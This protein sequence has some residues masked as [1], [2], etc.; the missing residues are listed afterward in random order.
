MNLPCNF[1]TISAD[2]QKCTTC[3]ALFHT[4]DPSRSCQN[5]P[6][7]SA[8]APSNYPLRPFERRMMRKSDEPGDR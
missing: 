8:P 3:G 2:R 4:S 7:Q 5:R 6:S 1:I